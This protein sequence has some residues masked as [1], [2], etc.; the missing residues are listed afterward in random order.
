MRSALAASSSLLAT[1]KEM[2]DELVWWRS[3]L[4]PHVIVVIGAWLRWI[5]NN[6]GG[7][8]GIIFVNDNGSA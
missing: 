8:G 6:R 2:D 7:K 1:A 3:S 5:G 4:K